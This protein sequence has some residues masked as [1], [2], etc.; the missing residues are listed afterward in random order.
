LEESSNRAVVLDSVNLL[1]DPFPVSTNHSYS[2]D[3]HTRL[4][5]F[6]MNVELQAGE[7][8]SIITA[9]A[10]DSQQIVY[11]LTIEYV[12]AVPNLNWLTQINVR[13]PDNLTDARDLLV[14]IKMRG[15]QSNKALVSIRPPP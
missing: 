9:E 5:L 15:L 7:T 3:G 10:E 6:A 14:R 8:F 2:L 11:P 12:G 4:M 13:L 1:R